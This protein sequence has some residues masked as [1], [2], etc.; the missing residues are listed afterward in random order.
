MIT[1]KHISTE[2][3]ENYEKILKS[4]PERG[5][6]YTFPNL[7]VWGRQ[8]MAEVSGCVVF[9]SQF[10]RR[11]VYPFPIGD[12]DIKAALDAVIHDSRAR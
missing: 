9:F 12:G 2:D 6:E 10:N 5:C 7:Y 1:F 4:A 3:R 11:T 8:T